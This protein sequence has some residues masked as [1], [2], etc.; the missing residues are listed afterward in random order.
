MATPLELAKRATKQQ[1]DAE[2]ARAREAA[3]RRA[4]EEA[5]EEYVPAETKCHV[6][7]FKY[8]DGHT[9]TFHEHDGVRM[10]VLTDLFGTGVYE[11]AV[12]E[13]VVDT[14]HYIPVK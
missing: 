3:A 9:E 13:E 1:E 10:D 4:A 6:R 2:K 12:L 11:T 14:V 5:G 8:S 7:T